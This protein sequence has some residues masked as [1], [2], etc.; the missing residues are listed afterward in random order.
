MIPTLLDAANTAGQTFGLD[1]GDIAQANVVRSQATATIR[2]VTGSI[3][4]FNPDGSGGD[5][6]LED[7]DCVPMEVRLTSPAAV[8]GTFSLEYDAMCFKVTSDSAGNDVINPGDP[9]PPSTA[10]TMLFLW[11]DGDTGTS[12]SEISLAY[13]P[14]A[15]VPDAMAAGGSTQS[16]AVAA[17]A[18]AH[19]PADASRYRRY[20]ECCGGDHG[21]HER[22]DFSAN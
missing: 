11:A 16:D 17:P 14:T 15:M 1:L 4:V 13:Q 8:V 20:G 22:E 7:G 6:G 5:D 19:G 2:A 3:T 10:G 12:T 9:I 21:D 18:R